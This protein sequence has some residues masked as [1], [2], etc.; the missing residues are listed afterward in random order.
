MHAV[1]F[2]LLRSLRRRFLWENILLVHKR[3]GSIDANGNSP[4]EVRVELL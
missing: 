3:R 2:Y 4:S 1:Q